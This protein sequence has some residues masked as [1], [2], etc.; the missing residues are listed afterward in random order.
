MKVDLTDY[1][2]KM[3]TKKNAELNLKKID[4]LN[5]KIEILEG[6]RKASILAKIRISKNKI[7]KIKELQEYNRKLK[8][9]SRV[10]SENA[11]FYKLK[12]Q[13][14]LKKCDTKTYK[15]TKLI[16]VAKLN[17]TKKLLHDECVEIS[18]ATGMTPGTI[19][20]LWYRQ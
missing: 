18:L 9:L 4:E 2:I 7:D 3:S 15:A 10:N 1:F 12:Y 5:L 17:R 14:L 11:V 13:A 8:A 19:R 16:E 6:K 20:T